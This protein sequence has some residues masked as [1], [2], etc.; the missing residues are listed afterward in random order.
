M[1]KYIRADLY[2]LW[3]RIPRL[4]LLVIV[5]YL[6]GDMFRPGANQDSTI[7]DLMD[8]FEEVL[9][10]VP[11]YFGVIELMYVFGDDFIGKTAQI[12][13][14][15]GV[16]RREVVF[17]KWIEIVINTAIDAVIITIIV[18]IESIIKTHT[19]PG[20]LLA[21]VL[22]HLLVAVMATAAY[23]AVVLPIMFAMQNIT[24]AFLLY[25]LFSS[26]LFSK[27]IDFLGNAV[28]FIRV[29]HLASYTLYNCL[30]VFRSRLILGSFS[31]TSFV[32]ML[33]YVCAGVAITLAV[34]KKKELEF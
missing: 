16:T 33:I 20:E 5:V 15:T 24:V 3:R 25:P 27:F 9:K 2:R 30:N 1:K 14:G 18:L 6:I 23:I 4:I 11:V 19:M 7:L 8:M 10:Y 32:G 17:S 29:H 31:I 28:K 34:Y 22:V 12:A 21:A 26:G 13:I